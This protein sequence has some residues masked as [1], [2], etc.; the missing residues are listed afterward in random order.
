MMRKLHKIR[1]L[2]IL[3]RLNVKKVAFKVLITGITVIESL[4]QKAL[5]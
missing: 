3:G 4:L 2:H 1:S 5:L